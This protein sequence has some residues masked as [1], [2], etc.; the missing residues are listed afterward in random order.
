MV[1]FKER[2]CGKLLKENNKIVLVL[3]VS[4]ITIINNNLPT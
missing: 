4:Y 2:R 3:V 1:A